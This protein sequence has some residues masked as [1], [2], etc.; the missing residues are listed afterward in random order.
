MLKSFYVYKCSVVTCMRFN[1]YL[2]DPEF[3]YFLNAHHNVGI[4]YFYGRKT[5]KTLH[6]Q[7]I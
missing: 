3:L 5:K 1:I 7:V 4:I 2:S 6:F